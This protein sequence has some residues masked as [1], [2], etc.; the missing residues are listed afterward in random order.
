VIVADGGSIDGTQDIVRR[1]AKRDPRI[2]LIHNPAR[3]QSA[4]INAAVAIADPASELIL[5]IDAHADYPPDFVRRTIETLERVGAHSVV[6][7]LVT[8]GRSS[9][10]R[11]VAAVL[12]SPVGSGGSIHRVGG[13]SGFVDHGHHALF[14]REVFA[15]L[16]GY[17]ESFVA[18]E[19]AEFDAR[20]RAWGGRIWFQNDIKIVYY[21]RRSLRAL[22]RQYW[23]YGTGRA[24]TF[25][26]HRERLRLRQLAAPLLVV[27]LVLSLLG[28]LAWLP[29]LAVPVSYVLALMGIGVGFAFQKRDMGML[30]AGSALGVVHLAWGAGFLTELVRRTSKPSVRNGAGKGSTAARGP[31]HA[32]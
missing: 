30:A 7:R 19:D 25:L 23:R 9:F 3:I 14:R 24:Q 10:E 11:A 31:D 4:G 20:I 2:R 12:N 15:A 27:T 28:A 17:D 1:L 6:V 18:N 22:A 26:K 16:G 8:T 21:P 5:R 29:F 32:R 13:A